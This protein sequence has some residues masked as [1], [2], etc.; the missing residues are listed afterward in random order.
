MNQQDDNEWTPLYGLL[1]SIF[2]IINKLTNDKRKQREDIKKAISFA[3][4]NTEKYYA[5]LEE[6]NARDRQRELDLAG[7]WES[8]AILIESVDQALANR[9]GLKGSFW[10]DGGTWDDA[11]IKGAGIQLN[12]IRAEGMTLLQPK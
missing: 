11:R 9:I 1:L 4:H 6:G 10:R 8:A 12:F 7:D 3:F 2:A 5:H